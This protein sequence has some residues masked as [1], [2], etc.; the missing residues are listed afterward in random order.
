MPEYP[1]LAALDQVVDNLRQFPPLVFAGEAR[2]LQADLAN[3]AGGHGFVL[4]GGDC[5]ESFGEFNSVKIR[6]TFRVLI[7]MAAVLNFGGLMHVVKIGRVAGQFS[8]PRSS[9]VETRGG[10]SLP[11]YRGDNI[12]GYDFDEKQRIPDP[13]RMLQGYNQATATLNLLRAFARGGYASLSRVHR[14]TLDFVARSPQGE[15]YAELASRIDECIEFMRSM[16]ITEENSSAIREAEFYTSHEALLLPYEE[17]MARIDSTTGDWYAT[18]AHMLWI[19]DR[20]RQLDGAHVEF[21]CGINNP[22][23]L[24]CGPSLSP[25]ELMHLI[26]RLNPGDTPGRLTLIAR[27][28]AAHIRQ[29]LPPLV[30]RVQREGRT[31]VWTSDPMHGN[32]HQSETG[33]KTRRFED[34]LDEVE[35]F[36]DVHDSLGTHAGGIHVEMTG[37]DVTECTGGAQELTDHALAERYHTVCDPRLNAS[38]SLELAFHVAERLRHRRQQRASFAPVP[39]MEDEP[40]GLIHSH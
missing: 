37:S 4:Q 9:P 25:D 17:P 32:T 11:V 8:K 38:Q 34:V 33:Y 28:G 26:D 40:M 31:V 36:F 16:G 22:I 19:G 7:Q 23:G 21:M 18:S 35:G 3:V 24:K 12:N 30:E 10:V 2:R 29:L 39:D 6:D 14:W 20:T 5:A 27:M 1:D 13:N 15:R